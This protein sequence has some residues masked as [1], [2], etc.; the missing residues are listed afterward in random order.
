MGKLF[1]RSLAGE[2]RSVLSSWRYLKTCSEIIQV[3]F[4]KFINS[5]PG[6]LI[7]RDGKIQECIFLLQFGF[8]VWKT[9]LTLK[10]HHVHKPTVPTC[11]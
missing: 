3:G 10:G 9:P 11:C 7:Y 1:V 2:A 8:P 5:D 4:S 6:S